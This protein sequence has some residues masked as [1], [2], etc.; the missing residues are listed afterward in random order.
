[1]KKLLMSFFLISLVLLQACVDSGESQMSKEELSID[2][3]KMTLP[4]GLDVILH[5]DKSDP[6]VAV[7]ILIHAG[8][9]REKPGRTGFAHFFEH[10]LFQRSENVPEGAFFKNINEWGGTFNGGTWTDGTVYYE[11]VPKD[12]LEKVLWMESD[13]M[14][15]FINSVTTASLEGE[16][17]VVQNEKRQRYDNVAYG[18]T[19]AVIN[20]A[21]YPPSHPYNWLTIGELEDLQNATLDDV[22]EFYEEYYGP[23]NAT[24]VLTGDFDK[25]STKKLIEKYFG[26]IPSRGTD[27]PLDPQPVK[28]D[29]TIQIYHEDNFASL[30]ELRLTWPTVEQYNKDQ[31]ALDVLGDILSDGKRAPL[32]KVIVEEGELAPDVSAY[33]SSNEL[34]GTFTI[35]VRA[36]AE[37]NL[38]TVKT[39]VFAALAKFEKEGVNQKDLDRIKAGLETNFYNGISSVLGKAF[40]L[41]TYNEFAGSPDYVKTDIKN[42]KAV[43]AEDV[44][45]VYDK[46][47]KGKHYILTSFVPKGQTA[48]AVGSSAKADIKEEAIVQNE[49][50]A[51]VDQE[52]SD[53]YARTESSFDRTIEP[54]F[55][56]APLL[57]P[58]TIWTSEL[59]NGMNVYGIEATELPLVNFSI[60]IDGG[61]KA[62]DP[63]K[64][65]VA[66]MITDLMMEGTKN[67]TPEELEDAIGQLGANVNMY[68]S[69][70]AI[71]I[72]ANC[73]SRNYD[74]TLALVQEILLEPRWDS[75]EFERIK[76][77]AVNRIQQRDVNPNSLAAMVM[78]VKLYGKD[79]ILGKPIAGTIESIESIT[80]DDMKAYY[81]KYFS[82]SIANFHLAGN[83]S[84]DKVKSSVASLGE[85]WAS[86]EVSFPELKS[87][88]V[89]ETPQVYFV[90]VPQAK[91]SVIQIAR[92][93]VSGNGED[94]F[95]LT[96]A[97]YRL[98][99]GSG[100]R[101]FQVLR[102]DKG[103]TYGAYSYVERNP[104]MGA[105]VASSSVKSNVTLE[106]MEAFKEVIG[107][108][109]ETY[110]DEDLEKTKNALIKQNTRKFET[111]YS[112]VGIL[113][114][115]SEYDL[116]L[117]YIDK[118]QETLQNMTVEDVQGLVQ[119]Y[120][121][122]NKMTYV[123]V[124]DKE[125]QLE[126]LKVDG[127]G[128]PQLIDKTGEATEPSM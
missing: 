20:K 126:R 31:W 105:F 124:G 116:P 38:D 121:D 67:K 119:K 9:D 24:L 10:M 25:E 17:P 37:V 115:I 64:V 99:A 22:K 80:L 51:V 11:V 109:A 90:D 112:L 120:M 43:T 65:G 76:K 95:P 40:Q 84:K 123:I 108:Y 30:P 87:N 18:N 118:E 82:P 103:Y 98:G 97:N 85:N 88:P 113:Q 68:T 70:D 93:A 107:T 34:A 1:M 74:S 14:G 16:K 32:Y 27:K 128:S 59:S 69:N 72:S 8:S 2:Y 79:N 6:I 48:L 91:Q 52:P 3:E 12:A 66:Y 49:Q 83:I 125:T 73:L 102:E 41:A 75:K 23:N 56:E 117:D 89:P 86:K 57:T 53:D 47:I 101:L 114:T 127:I 29:S 50:T 21:L 36:N 55:G 60:R 26:E 61:H 46:Y 77:A 63:N 39:E 7:A 100:G 45:A 111:L 28:L 96:V 62:D 19:S 15:Y 78:D 94:Y 81:N 110:T 58:P 42:I 44:K 4:N 122:L 92:L 104:Y 54:E 35:R 13:R 106:A 5:Q 71:T 33:N